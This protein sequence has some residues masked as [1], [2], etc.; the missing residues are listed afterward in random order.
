MQNKIKSHINLPINLKKQNFIDD[1]LIKD[2]IQNS[3][4]KFDII[5]SSG[6][7]QRLTQ[8]F[9][10]CVFVL[11]DNLLAISGNIEWLTP[12]LVGNAWEIFRTNE[13]VLAKRVDPYEPY[14]LNVLDKVKSLFEEVFPTYIKCIC[15]TGDIL[16]DY[17]I[18]KTDTRNVFRIIFFVICCI[19]C[20][21]I[22]VVFF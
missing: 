6:T 15:C 22:K 1:N 7:T 19:C 18:T 21:L 20:I 4:I 5:I 2:L 16:F 11:G 13:Y 9:D 10:F 17:E 3:N 12:R 14:W 8:R